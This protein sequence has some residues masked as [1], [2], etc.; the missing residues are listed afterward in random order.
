MGDLDV[1]LA[2]EFGQQ[3]ED[4]GAALGVHGAALHRDDDMVC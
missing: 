1:A 2:G 4:F 3:I